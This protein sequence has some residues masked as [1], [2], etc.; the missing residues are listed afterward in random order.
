MTRRERIRNSIWEHAFGVI[1]SA[2]PAKMPSTAIITV[3]DLAETLD[4]A[5]GPER[6][7]PSREGLQAVL[8]EAG[9]CTCRV[10]KQSSCMYTTL[11]D[12]LM[13]WATGQTT[14][15]WC[16]HM[17]QDEHTNWLCFVEH[18]AL[19][20]SWSW[21]IPDHYAKFCPICGAPRPEG[22]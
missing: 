10:T 12:R 2:W 13:A 8:Q 14:P 21:N 1:R 20:S 6:P 15:T 9:L 18:K 4:A 19:A 11:K 16:E 3:D 5:L 17:R 7:A 22:G